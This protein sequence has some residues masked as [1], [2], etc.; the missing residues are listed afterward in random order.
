M[1]PINEKP[2]SVGPSFEGT[3]VMKSVKLPELEESKARAR[4]VEVSMTS[5]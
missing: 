1:L 3:T 4:F 5:F 2:S